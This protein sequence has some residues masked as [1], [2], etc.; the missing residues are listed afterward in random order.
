MATEDPSFRDIIGDIERSKF[1]PV[2]ILSGEEPYYLDRIIKALEDKVV[3][4][5]D[6]DFNQNIFFGNDADVLDVAAAAQQFPVMSSRRLVVLKEAQSMPQ[7]KAKLEKLAPY[8]AKPTD[9]TVFALVF[10]GENLNATSKLIKSASASG[11]AVIF[12]SPKIKDYKLAGP[13]KDYCASKKIGIEEKAVAML[14]DYIGNPLDKLF[15]EIDKLI[16]AKGNDKSRITSKD[17]EDN[18]GISKDF[19]NYELVSAI[20]R[21]DY[22]KCVLIIRHFARNPKQNP[23]VLT[24]GTLFN[25]FSNIVIGHYAADKTDLGL[26]KEM[27]LKNQYSLKDIKPAM[28]AYSPMKAVRAIHFIREFDCKSKGINSTQNEYDLLLELVFSIIAQ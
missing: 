23:T 17:I 22:P 9:T 27:G 11:K 28:S 19:N 7:A 2:Y 18:I 13:V 15:G 20:A 4:S 21:K 1:S 16:V 5:S 26:V 12:R 25:L 6:R 24:T 3:E 8:L 14:C 10:K